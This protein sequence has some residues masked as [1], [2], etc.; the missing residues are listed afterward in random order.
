MGPETANIREPNLTVLERETT[1]SPCA[2]D[3][4]DRRPAM[5]AAAL[6]ISGRYDGMMGLFHGGT[7]RPGHRS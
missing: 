4:R 7:C 2:A 6:S 3:R 1:R 5:S